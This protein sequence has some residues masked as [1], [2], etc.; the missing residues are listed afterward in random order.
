MLKLIS[1]M[2]TRDLLAEVAMLFRQKTGRQVDTEAAGGVEVARRI[3]A[4][5]GADVV[6]LASEVIDRLM[7]EGRLRPGRVDIAESQIAVA[8]RAG[9][10]RPDLASEDAVRRSVGRTASIGYSTGP[11]GAW[12]EQL[13]ARWGLLEPL[14]ERIVVPA[15]GVPVASLVADGTVELG[16]QQLSELVGRPGIDIVGLLPSAIQCRT[17]FSGGVGATSADPVVARALLQFLGSAAVDAVRQ[18]HGLTAPNQR[19]T[20]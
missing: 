10:R 16:F 7:G 12:I 20:G 4:G 19:E 13:L 5:E 17:T 14:Q 11:S 3:R 1:S 15:P 6:V 9:A 18:R 8:V 2:A